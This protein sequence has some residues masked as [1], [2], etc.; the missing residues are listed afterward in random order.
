M[1]HTHTLYCQLKVKEKPSVEPPTTTLL[2]LV[3]YGC[4]GFDLFI[5]IL[6]A[7]GQPLK[8]GIEKQFDKWS[9]GKK[10]TPDGQFQRVSD[11]YW[12]DNKNA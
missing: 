8:V 7:A 12:P 9:I 2:Q 11:G 4:H 5:I 10:Q 3:I 1:C 6:Q